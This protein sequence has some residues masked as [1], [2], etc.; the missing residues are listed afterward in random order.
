MAQAVL[1]FSKANRHLQAISVGLDDL[2][3]RKN[4]TGIK[5]SYFRLSKILH[6][7][8][9]VRAHGDGSKRFLAYATQ[10]MQSLNR[11]KENLIGS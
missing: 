10:A 11:S 4:V 9:L 8:K 3:S 1:D 6:P 2:L 7:D 5:K